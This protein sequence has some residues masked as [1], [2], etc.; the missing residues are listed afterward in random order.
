MRALDTERSLSRA[1]RL[2]QVEI[3]LEREKE[4]DLIMALRGDRH[5]E[6][7]NY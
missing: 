2:F 3:A 1:C 7:D 6:L 4:R 5:Q